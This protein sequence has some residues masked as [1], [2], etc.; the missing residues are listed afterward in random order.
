[1][2][3]DSRQQVDVRFF[4]AHDRAWVPAAHCILF[5]EKDPNKTKGSTP[6]N[7]KNASKTQ[8]GIADAMKE[9]DDYIDNLNKK[10]GFKYFQLRQQ[11][12]PNDLKSQLDFM[13]PG[14]NT[15]K[16]VPKDG[17]N[18]DEKELD[19]SQKEK[20]T[21]KIVKGQS[22]YQ[23]EQKTSEQRTP[24]VQKPLEK[25]KPKLYKVLSKNDD[26]M[27][28]EQPGRLQPLIIKRKSNVEQE[29]EKSKRSKASD[30]MS[31][32]SESNASTQNG[33]INSSRRKSVRDSVKHKKLMKN[34]DKDTSHEPLPK[35]S[36][37]ADKQK[38]TNDDVEQ[39][40]LDEVGKPKT[41][42]RSRAKS[43]L[44]ESDKPLLV[45]LVVPPGTDEIEALR[46]VSASPPA[47]K[48]T[49]NRSRSFHRSRSI[50]KEPLKD[51][52]LSHRISISSPIKRSLSDATRKN[53]HRD[54]VAKSPVTEEVKETLSFNPHLV[55][56]DE[57]VSENEEILQRDT[58]TLNDIP[59]LMQDRSGKKKL[60]VISTNDN[61]EASSSVSTQ[62]Q[63]G[64]ARKTFPNNP[65]QSQLEALTSQ[66]LQQ[67]RNGNW[68]ICIPQAFTSPAGTSATVQT[69]SL[70]SPPT[71]NR[72][73]PASDS[74][75]SISQVRSNQSS[76]RAT[77]NI[78]T[79]AT[80]RSLNLNVPPLNYNVNNT[81]TNSNPS[82]LHRRNSIH[83]NP[84]F[85]NGQ[86][87]A[88]TGVSQ[89]N[90]MQQRN[91]HPE[92]PPRLVPRPK[93][94]FTNDGCQ[95]NRDI[96]PVSRLFQ[97]NGHRMS[98]YFRSL[99]MDTIASFAPE[100]PTAE[101]LMLRAENEKINREMQI[102]KSDC[103]LK[104]QELR[105]EHQDEIDS[106]KKEHGE[107]SFPVNSHNTL[108]KLTF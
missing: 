77:P 36:K 14:L 46:E 50:E 32:T 2:S 25:D 52:K 10:F 102:T 48:R 27:D 3:V 101:N 47:N 44:P 76:T 43:A 18:G 17:Q 95:F 21:M 82:S 85:I 15:S 5:S 74:Q 71:S 7:T 49:H 88:L 96:G 29:T 94:V 53:S 38:P 84:F 66:Q 31:E 63:V 13:L 16:E 72:S 98:D 106:I 75:I 65:N 24:S 1:M 93:G 30:T 97:D 80:N 105:R 90:S 6:T 99:L 58:F 51:T 57:P 70:Q 92:N 20:L 61:G 23:V 59:N 39:R 108:N 60:I 35:K 100:V 86:R 33:K 4:G 40:L 91:H 26:N 81:N 89:P 73:T 67:A 62:Q 68:M 78:S 87:V 45:A 41:V 55:I 11:F 64:R 8:K 28:L 69:G 83:S 19:G 103:Q 22:S 9:K 56:K 79:T 54:S 37:H 107:F 12:D 104:M 42:K 34:V